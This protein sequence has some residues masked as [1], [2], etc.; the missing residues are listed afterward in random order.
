MDVS[1][2]AAKSLGNV[3]RDCKKVVGSHGGY[4]SAGAYYEHWG[5]VMR[6][7]ALPRFETLESD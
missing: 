1:D 6:D 2:R 7:V 5:R 4:R 3:S